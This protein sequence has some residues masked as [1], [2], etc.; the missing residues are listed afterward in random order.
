M[1]M[2]PGGGATSTL[3]SDGHVLVTG[4]DYADTSDPTW[5]AQLYYPSTDAWTTTGGLAFPRAGHTA[6]LLRD[7]RV[8][9]AGCA[10]TRMAE[11]YDPTRFR[12]SPTGALPIATCYQTAVLLDDGRVLLAG[13]SD[14]HTFLKS[15]EIYDP[16]TGEFTATGSMTVAREHA[17]SV[18]LLDGRV[19]VMGGDQGYSNGEWAAL[20]SAETYDPATGKFTATGSMAFPRTDF[21]VPMLASRRVLVAG[22]TDIGSL[23][24]AETYD[25]ASGTFSV[26]NSWATSRADYLPLELAALSD[27]RSTTAGSLG[28]GPLQVLYDRKAGT[29]CFAP[30]Q[31]SGTAAVPAVTL[32]DGRIMLPGPQPMLYV[33]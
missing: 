9:I 15:A 25:P 2:V 13:G 6:T 32:L 10:D 29:F 19:L 26:F 16:A 33:P 27:W 21:R 24:T 1:L 8:L 30:P 14:G 22:G 23:S 5:I 18:M 11:L 31:P 20:R 28:D 12:S 4:G 7:G 3:L 17:Q